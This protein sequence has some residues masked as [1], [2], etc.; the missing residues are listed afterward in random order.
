MAPSATRTSSE[1]ALSSTHIKSQN[2]SV[3]T[4]PEH[5]LYIKNG[6]VPAPGPGECLI[7][8]RATGICGS[9]IHF[10][11]SGHIGDMIVVGENRLGHE[12]A[13]VVVAVGEGVNRFKLGMTIDHFFQRPSHFK[14]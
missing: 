8:V 10:W 9:D 13:G 2:V 1:S 12:S 6:P 11:K 14:F 7:H 4:N 3:F 5:E